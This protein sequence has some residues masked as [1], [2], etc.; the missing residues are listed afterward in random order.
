MTDIEVEKIKQ[1]VLELTKL[2]KANDE[3]LTTIKAN[4]REEIEQIEYE[5]DPLTISIYWT[6]LFN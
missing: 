5:I 2:F 6:I 3:I 4:S 1:E